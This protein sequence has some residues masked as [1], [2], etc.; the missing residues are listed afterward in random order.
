MDFLAHGRRRRGASTGWYSAAARSSAGQAS[1]PGAAIGSL[2]KSGL[3]P[4]DQRLFPGEPLQ[5]PDAESDKDDEGDRGGDGGSDQ[6]AP[7]AGVRAV[8]AGRPLVRSRASS[9]PFDPR[10]FRPVLVLLGDHQALQRPEK[11]DGEDRARAGPRGD[12]C[13]QNGGPNENSTYSARP[14]TMKPTIMMMKT[15]GPS[16]ESL[17]L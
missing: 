10:L 2:V 14:T 9:R 1:G 13:T 6:L 16:P 4:R 5:L 12:M 15:A 17:K 11:A 7:A 8:S 3:D